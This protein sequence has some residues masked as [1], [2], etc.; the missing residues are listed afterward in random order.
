MNDGED[1]RPGTRTPRWYRGK[2]FL[3]RSGPAGFGIKPLGEWVSSL[4]RKSIMEDLSSSGG[5][6]YTAVVAGAH[7]FKVGRCSDV[8][9]TIR[10]YSTGFGVF[11]MRFFAVLDPVTAERKL[12]SKLG[13]AI[14]GEVFLTSNGS[15]V[16][17]CVMKDIERFL[18]LQYG[19]PVKYDTYE[20]CSDIAKMFID[21]EQSPEPPVRE[22]VPE[23]IPKRE[24]VPEPRDTED[25]EHMNDVWV[26]KMWKVVIDDL[27]D[28]YGGKLQEHLESDDR[29]IR[30]RWVLDHIIENEVMMVLRDGREA[31]KKAATVPDTPHHIG[32]D[33]ADELTALRRQ[34]HE[35]AQRCAALERV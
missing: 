1:P 2:D 23:P 4:K 8:Q 19:Q 16:A 17:H 11:R 10:R 14:K 27:I 32:Q 18:V 22:D 5:Y 26:A 7:V 15:G 13:P 35:L 34:M 29:L 20:G 33:N 25:V 31:I 21:Y 30:M 9:Y 12:L 24:D 6:V 3:F 28:T